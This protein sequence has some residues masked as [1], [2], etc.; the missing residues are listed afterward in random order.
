MKVVS[1]TSYRWC[2]GLESKRHADM[3]LELWERL[4]EAWTPTTP[5]RRLANARGTSG[6]TT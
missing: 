5:P 2:V 1:D 3:A 4:K 6:L